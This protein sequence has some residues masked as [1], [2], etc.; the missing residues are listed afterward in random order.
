MAERIRVV[1]GPSGLD[2]LIILD[3]TTLGPAVGGVRT[4]V[5][6]TPG[7]LEEDARRLARAMTIK[8]ALA[9]LAAGGGKI[10]VDA[11]KLADRARAFEALGVAV[12]ELGGRLL[13]A[14][15]YGTTAEDL[16]CMARRTRQVHT[17]PGLP[18]AVARGL[19]GC[20]LAAVRALGHQALFGRSALVQGAGTI[21]AA[22]ARALGA[23]GASVIVCDLDPARA[24]AVAEAIGAREIPA[25]AALT[26]PCDLFVPCATG[27][28]IDLAVAEVLPAR[29][30]VGGANNVLASAEAGARL[31]AR[32][33]L[34]VPDP[35]S[36]AG[37]VIAGVAPR[38][39]RVAPEPLIDAL[40]ATAASVL[41]EAKATQRP[42][43][44]VAYRRAQARVS[45]ATPPR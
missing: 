21:G 39:M 31:F 18:E 43:G 10:V 22:V 33:V 2:A 8:C 12:E 25:E 41:L 16:A 38:L 45:H 37:A 32:G 26:T 15:D 28:V 7:A 11:S 40:G 34:E 20:A 29:A 19:V 30:V 17:A 9:G 36:S 27:G 5:Y 3:D 1:D 6:P 4:R 14:G 24:H 13:T 42:P 23:A 44:E 35:I